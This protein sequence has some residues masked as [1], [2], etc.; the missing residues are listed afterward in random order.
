VHVPEITATDAADNTYSGH[1]AAYERMKELLDPGKTRMNIKEKYIVEQSM[2]IYVSTFIATNHINCIGLPA[3]DRRIMAVMNTTTKMTARQIKDA[4]D[5]YTNKNNLAAL[6]VWAKEWQRTVYLNDSIPADTETK[7]KI[8]EAA[9]PPITAA[10]LDVIDDFVGVV[11]YEAQVLAKINPP[12]TKVDQYESIIRSVCHE[13]FS[14]VEPEDPRKKYLLG[15]ESGGMTVRPWV[16]TG[17]INALMRLKLGVTRG[18]VA[19]EIRKNN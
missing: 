6:L 17:D 1:K 7:K 4:L 18:L 16:K 14:R 3:D 10:I 9:V 2:A 5:W 15:K 12:T 19:E 11:F 13:N 8:A